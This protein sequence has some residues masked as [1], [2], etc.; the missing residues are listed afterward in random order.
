[1]KLLQSYGILFLSLI[2]LF[3]SGVFVGRLTSPTYRLATQPTVNVPPDAGEWV[4]TASRGLGKDLKLDE[5]QLQAVRKQLEPVATMIF[6][7]QERGLFQMHLRL[8]ELHDTLGRDGALNE[9]QL[10]RLGASRA[11]LKNLIIQK[12]PN[13]VR[14]NPTFAI[15]N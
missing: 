15:G 7:D 10:K 13:R 3:A 11:K 6:A 1:M 2:A 4:L 8:L 9:R 5:N 12:F 14:E